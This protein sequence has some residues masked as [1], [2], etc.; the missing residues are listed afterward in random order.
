MRRSA[1]DSGQR[2][3][4]KTRMPFLGMACTH[5]THEIGHNLVLRSAAT[6][7]KPTIIP[8]RVLG[9]G[10]FGQLGHDLPPRRLCA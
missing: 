2:I 6:M 8:V 9:S 7:Q 4:A 3:R 10:T 5:Q 1:M